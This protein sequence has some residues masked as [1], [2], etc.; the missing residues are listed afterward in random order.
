MDPDEPNKAILR[1]RR[2]GESLKVAETVLKRRDRNLQAAAERAKQ[3]AQARKSQKQSKHKGKLN[4]IRAE[5]LVKDCRNRQIDRRRLKNAGKKP[6]PKQQKGRILAAVRNGRL[7]GSK[8]AKVTLRSLGLHRRH[9][10][11]FLPNNKDTATKL[12]SAQ[13]Y[14]FWGV[15]TFK[16]ICS[17][18]HKRA[19]FRDPTKPNEHTPLSDNVLIEQHLGD[20]GMVCTEDLAHVIHTCSGKFDK[21]NER[22]WPFILGDAKKSSGKLVNDKY[23][24]T[25]NVAADVNTKMAQ[26]LGENV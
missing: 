22:L 4:I 19:H 1:P 10:M 17:L 13:P 11:V 18:I 7:G 25:G 9:T 20:L 21:V 6:L 2:P 24:T 26:L 14:A 15:P 12:R 16:M 5:R 8:E 3:I 23:Y